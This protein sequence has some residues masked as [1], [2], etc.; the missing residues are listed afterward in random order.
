MNSNK[1][2]LNIIQFGKSSVY[3]V[4]GNDHKSILQQYDEYLADD[5]IVIISIFYQQKGK[6]LYENIFKDA[7]EIFE[8]IDASDI[9]VSGITKKKAHDL[10]PPGN[11]SALSFLHG[12]EYRSSRR[13]RARMWRRCGWQNNHH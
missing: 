3:N 6:R 2:I 12:G 11:T 13:A 7:A 9:D 10:K 1:I 5:G 4:S 8:K